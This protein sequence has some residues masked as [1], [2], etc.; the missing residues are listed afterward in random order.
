[1]LLLRAFPTKASYLSTDWSEFKSDSH[2]V[3]CRTI[4][5]TMV[6]N[7]VNTNAVHKSADETSYVKQQS[8]FPFFTTSAQHQSTL[9]DGWT[10]S[11]KLTRFHNRHR[12]SIQV[13]N[14][15][16]LAGKSMTSNQ[17]ICAENS[18]CYMLLRIPVSHHFTPAKLR[19]VFVNMGLGTQDLFQREKL[20]T[21]PRRESRDKSPHE[22]S[23]YLICV[24]ESDWN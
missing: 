9:G 6:A 1:M 13:L 23:P 17:A 8:V 3:V 12:E 18:A 5:R 20:P 10:L 14:Q 11:F 15:T 2:G 7:F 21:W 22:K 19:V 16:D 4:W 24:D